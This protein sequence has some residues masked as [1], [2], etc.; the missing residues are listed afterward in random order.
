MDNKNDTK[1]RK[2]NTLKSAAKEENFDVKEVENNISI[3]EK[4]NEEIQVNNIKRKP[5]QKRKRKPEKG[6]KFFYLFT[7]T[8]LS[9][10][11][12]F[13]IGMIS[14]KVHS[15]VSE[16]ALN[17]QLQNEL[18][19]S[20]E[21][22]ETAPPQDNSNKTVPAYPLATPSRYQYP[23][24]ITMSQIMAL[25]DKNSDFACWLYIPS[26]DIKPISY[27][28][29]QAE[30]NNFYL[31]KNIDKEYVRSGSLF[32]D[33][34]NDA[35][36]MEGHTIIYGHNMHDGSMFGNVLKYYQ[37]KSGKFM[38]DH[39]YIYTYSKTGVSVWQVFSVYET[40]TDEDYIKTHFV[41]DE[42]YYEFIKDLQEKSYFDTDIILKATDDVLTLSTCYKF[43]AANGRLTVNAVRVGQS[44]LN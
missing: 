2:T 14:N 36:T 17:R 9:A 4:D 37:D 34:R 20:F 25:E 16:A 8:I 29:M 15:Y 18:G 26:D 35:E 3:K 28:V 33:C 7:Q 31:Y 24:G 32:L 23:E 42:E 40:T 19:I 39:Q 12:F 6:T 38:R 41:N 21:S 11:L 43:N 5:G 44:I 30:D 10:I 27:N 1:R 22:A 13:T